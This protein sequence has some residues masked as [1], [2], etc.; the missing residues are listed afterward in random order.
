MPSATDLPRLL[1]L[2]HQ[3]LPSWCDRFLAPAGSGDFFASRAWYDTVL[4]HALP[5]GSQPLLAVGE[6]CLLLPLLREGGGRLRSL[7]T[8]Y[9]LSWRP[10]ATRKEDIGGAARALG[11]RLRSEPLVQLDTLDAE[12]PGLDSL[13]NG[14]RA[15]GFLPMT[16]RHFGNWWQQLEKGT[17]WAQ[18]LDGRPPPLRATIQRKLARAQRESRFEL[19]SCPGAELEAGIQAYEE[20]RAKSWKPHEPF[21]AFDAALMRAA[22]R[23]GA[24]RLGVLR[25]SCGR[26]LAAQYWVTSG[27]HAA[28]LKL[29]H[30][31]AER[32]ASPGTVLTARMIEWLIDQERVAALDLGRGDDAYKPLWVQQRRQRMGVL[33]ANPLRPAGLMAVARQA[34]GRGRRQALQ[35]I[36]RRRDE[37]PL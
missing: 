13:L 21:P 8:P 30:V 6:D 16:F 1:P 15:A 4:A 35:W 12:L 25:S 32:K 29:A 17:S 23:C 24:L 22:S 33:L 20:V 14:M 2:H 37:N 9:T 31:E 5:Q 11:Q 28:L 3:G 34:A 27:S 26:A 19:I 36:G 18:Y 7:S 10:L